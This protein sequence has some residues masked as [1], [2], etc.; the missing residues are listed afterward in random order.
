MT[1]RG[2]AAGLVAIQG[3]EPEDPDYAYVE[4]G[5]LLSR[6]E[7]RNDWLRIQEGGTLS[8]GLLAPPRLRS[9]APS[10]PGWKSLGPDSWSK[11]GR[12][13]LSGRGVSGEK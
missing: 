8:T 11:V 4:M 2:E 12:Q 9:P 1:Q 10:V 7:E 13:L 5:K 6:K 3:K